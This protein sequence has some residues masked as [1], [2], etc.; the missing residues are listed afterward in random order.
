MMEFLRRMFRCSD[1]EPYLVKIEEGQTIYHRR[2]SWSEGRHIT[3][4][5]L[6]MSDGTVW[7]HPYDGSAPIENPKP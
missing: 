2:Y 7:F 3:G 6:T 5:R 4:S 1:P